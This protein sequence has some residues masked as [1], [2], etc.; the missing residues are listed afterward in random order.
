MRYRENGFK[1]LLHK[2]NFVFRLWIKFM[3][4]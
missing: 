3:Q 4:H 1:K 2:Q